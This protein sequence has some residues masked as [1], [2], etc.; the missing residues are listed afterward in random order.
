MLRVLILTSC[1]GLTAKSCW[2]QILAAQIIALVFLLIFAHH[3]PYR[4]SKHRNLHILAQVVPIVTLG[5]ML[6]GGWEK[7]KL[8]AQGAMARDVGEGYDMTAM[9]V[10]HLALVVPPLLFGLHSLVSSFVVWRLAKRERAIERKRSG[11]MGTLAAA[12]AGKGGTGAGAPATRRPRKLDSEASVQ[13]R[14]HER[15]SKLERRLRK[16]RKK[17][18]REH[19]RHEAHQESHVHLGG[20]APGAAAAAGGMD[21]MD[22]WSS[23]S[24]DEGAGAGPPPDG[25]GGGKASGADADAEAN[26]VVHVADSGGDASGDASASEDTV[27]PLS[28]IR[29][30]TAAKPKLRRRNTLKKAFTRLNTEFGTG[31]D[32]IDLAAFLAACGAEGDADVAAATALFRLVDED[33]SGT[34]EE[35]EL[36][37]ALRKNEDAARGAERFPALQALLDSGKKKKKKKRDASSK[38]KK[39]FKRVD[40]DGSGSIDFD[41]FV[42]LCKEGGGGG[43]DDGVYELF[44][45]L[46]EDGDG[47]IDV[48]EL[49]HALRTDDAAAA[50][51]RN[52]PALHAFLDTVDEHARRKDRAEARR[53]KRNQRRSTV[54]M[55]TN[56]A[57]AAAFAQRVSQA[58]NGGGG[59]EGGEGAR[60]SL[61]RRGSMKKK[62]KGRRKTKGKH[63][64]SAAVDAA[65]AFG[66]RHSA[67]RGSLIGRLAAFKARE[68]AASVRKAAEGP[69]Q[70][71]VVDR[72]D[73]ANADA[74]ADGGGAAA[75][76]GAGGAGG[77]RAPGGIEGGLH[78]AWD[79]K[80]DPKSGRMFYVHRSSGERTW[81][82][83]PPPPKITP[84]ARRGRA[85]V[86]DHCDIE[87]IRKLFDAVD[88][89]G[90]EH[91]SPGEFATFLANAAA[92]AGVDALPAADV[93]ATFVFVDYDGSG[94]IEREELERFLAV[95]HD[96]NINLLDV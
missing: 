75:A 59:G 73:G 28:E 90:D 89:D 1:I 15:G 70:G 81:T 49:S 47:E 33:G 93:D 43:G 68:R 66:P 36:V 26:A 17:R 96:G 84:G 19:S 53:A 87:N 38:F 44:A 52:F 69:T 7:W 13:T 8:E 10:L 86:H 72:D 56:M 76:D 3:R 61:K 51:A 2:H 71:D 11:G 24:S 82:R 5:W 77:A 50:L 79:E 16:R 42:E 35:A 23:S 78:P 29:E 46:D 31:S 58:A 48:G 55:A 80:V 94:T 60:P 30:G 37:H 18:E 63:Q 67:R 9:L 20:D 14:R 22:S 25:G 65:R 41:E 95:F 91:L 88:S 54:R 64:L 27:P 32:H 83:P 74:D 92:A 62:T 6:C 45:K 4:R 40:A 39:A 57:A 85:F 34:L 21:S 12:L